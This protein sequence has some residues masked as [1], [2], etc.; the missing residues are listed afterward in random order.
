LKE[1][2][3]T[4]LMDWEAVHALEGS[5][6]PGGEFLIEP[7]E[8]EALCSL[9]NCQ[10]ASDGTAHPLYAY[11]AT[12]RAMGIT[13]DGLFE[14]FGLSMESGPMLATTTLEFAGTPLR[15]ATKYQV[16]GQIQ[17]V[18]RKVG[19]KLG[20]FDLVAVELLLLE[21]GA[22]AARATNSFVMPRGAGG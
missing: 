6:L 8:N 9:L 10:P 7:S 15:T 13:V 1:A 3:S 4:H 5:L 2:T 19:R 18:E 22:P 20:V 16:R 14:M 11:I 21:N 17:K 12:Q